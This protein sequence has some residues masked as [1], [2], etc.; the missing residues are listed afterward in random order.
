MS[1]KENL[2]S[3]LILQKGDYYVQKDDNNFKIG[4]VIQGVLRGFVDNNEGNEI[5]THF[6]IESDIVSGNFIPN[7]PATINIQ[8]MENCKIYS[9]NYKD[10]YTHINNDSEITEIINS[11]FQKLNIQIQSRLVSLASKNAFEKYKL[12]LKEYP[13]LLN[14][15]PHYHIASFLGITPTQLSRVRK[16]FSQQ[17]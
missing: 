8:A 2:H 3:E 5:T 10:V 4:K 7:I 1:L 17:M 16:L 6:F 12:F 9:A 11:S 14:R 15:V 13:N